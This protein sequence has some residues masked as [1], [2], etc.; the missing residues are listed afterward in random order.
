MVLS[1]VSDSPV[2]VRDL[3][4]IGSIQQ[5]DLRVGDDLAKERFRVRLDR[6]LSRIQMVGILYAEDLD[7]DLGQRYSGA[8]YRF[9][10]RAVGWT[11]C[12]LRLR[13][14]QGG[15]CFCG[16]PGCKEQCGHAALERG[17]MCGVGERVGGGLLAWQRT[18]V[19]GRAGALPNINL[20]SCECPM[21]IDSARGLF[22]RAHLGCLLLGSGLIV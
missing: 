2:G 22:F 19:G 8:N 16:L 1:T 3:D 15:E 9:R 17:G 20:F 12:D 13:P 10:C 18:G 14:V 7:S 6:C 4:D 11:R 21:R 5:V